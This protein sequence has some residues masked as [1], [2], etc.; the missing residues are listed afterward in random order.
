LQRRRRIASDTLAYD[1]QYR[2]RCR[3]CNRRSGFRIA[4]VDG[5]GRGDNS[6]PERERVV[7]AGESG[8]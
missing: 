7:V 2:L 1:L 3:R 4:V 5:R 8:G 6:V